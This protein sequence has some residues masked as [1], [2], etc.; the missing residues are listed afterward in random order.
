MGLF[1]GTINLMRLREVTKSKTIELVFGTSIIFL[2]R[3]T[4]LVFEIRGTRIAISNS[5]LIYLNTVAFSIGRT[6][7]LTEQSDNMN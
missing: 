1:F 2:L 3:L 4:R 6:Q 7:L 5:I